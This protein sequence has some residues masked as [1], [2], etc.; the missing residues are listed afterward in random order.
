MKFIDRILDKIF[1][2][3]IK[4][5]YCDN[6]YLSDGL[7]EK[8]TEKLKK[9]AEQGKGNACLL[10]KS[11]NKDDC[12]DIVTSFQLKSKVWEGK[13]PVCIGLADGKDSAVELVQTII[14]DCLEKTGKTDLKEFICSL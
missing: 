6:L 13:S 7:S 4:I 14:R 10:L 2:K 9:K 11:E 1:R 12:I 8:K 5:I 3:D